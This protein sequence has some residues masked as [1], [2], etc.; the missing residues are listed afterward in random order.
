MQGTQWLSKLVD[1]ALESVE[2][3]QKT[4][5]EAM[6]MLQDASTQPT[7]KSSPDRQMCTQMTYAYA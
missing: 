4:V 6:V 2:D 7:D 3:E 5:Q 1:R